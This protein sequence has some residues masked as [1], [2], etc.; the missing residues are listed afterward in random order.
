MIFTVK[1]RALVLII[2]L[3]A[4]PFILNLLGVDFASQPVTLDS[5]KLAS[6]IISTSNQSKPITNTLHHVFMEWIAICISMLI[7]LMSFLHFYKKRDIAVPIVGM[8]FLCTGLT[9]GFHI[10]AINSVVST[11]MLDDFIPFSWAFARFFSAT[12]I[13]SGIAINLWIFR[14]QQSVPTQNLQVTNQ[15]K[16]LAI[17]CLLLLTTTI[18]FIGFFSIGIEIPKT[19]FPNALLSRPYDILPLSMLVFCGALAW[20]WYRQFPTIIKYMLLLSLIPLGTAQLHMIF[21]STSLL[22]NDFNIAHMLKIIA[23]GCVFSGILID[24]LRQPSTSNPVTFNETND[25]LSRDIEGLVEVGKAA[26]PQAFTIPLASFVLAAI[27]SLL[28]GG[29]FYLNTEKLIRDQEVQE[30]KIESQLVE[31]LLSNFYKE[32][33]SDVLFLS[34]S[35]PVQELIKSIK[36]K[37]LNEQARWLNKLEQAFSLMLE[38]KQ[39][40][41]KIR[42]IGLENDGMELVNVFRDGYTIV[43]KKKDE[44]QTKIHR[45]YFKEMLSLSGGEIYFSQIELN[46]EH[47]EISVPYQPVIRVGTSIYDEESRKLF[48]FIVISA[49]FGFFVDNLLQTSLKDINFYLAN[50]K[51]DYLIHP[52]TSKTFGFDLGKRYLIQEEFPS[53]TNIIAEKKEQFIMLNDFWL[54]DESAIN[55]AN[56]VYRLIKPHYLNSQNNLHLLLTFDH[57]TIKKVLKN[58]R[59]HSLLIG[60]G[61]AVIALAI[62]VFGARRLTAPLLQTTSALKHF[63]HTGELLPLPTNSKDEIGVLARSFHNMLTLKRARDREL[64]EQKFALDQH[65]IVAVTDV[66]GTITFANEKFAEISGYTINELVGKNHNIVNSHYHDAEFWRK[67]YQTITRGKVWRGELRNITKQGK[68]Y[69]VDTTI[70]PFM[71]VNGKPESYIAIRTDITERKNMELALS[72]N[73]EHLELVID[74]TAVGI[75]DWKVQTD[76]VVFNERWAE[77]IG[78]QL[79][80]LEPTDINTWSGHCHPDDLVE[81]G[82]Q[83]ERHW[84]GETKYYSCEAR[85]MH[86][87]GSW[88]WVLDTGKVV[89]WCSDGKP[90]RMIGTHLDITE[91]K[92]AELA[93]TETMTLLESTIE[94]TDN[95]ILVTN[96]KGEVLRINT[97]FVQLWNL[98]KESAESSDESSL[99]QHI[100]AYLSDPEILTKSLSI[101]NEDPF[102]ELTEMLTLTDGK[103]IENISHPMLMNNT[104]VGRIWSFRDVTQRVVAEQQQK[105]L[106]ESTQTKLNVASVLNQKKPLAQRLDDVLN[107]ILTIDGIKQQGAIYLLD[108]KKQSIGITLLS[109]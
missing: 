106:L 47:R 24:L 52:D 59:N 16:I 20:N 23:Y 49:D 67:M 22:D 3:S 72:E 79:K 102:A 96:L 65:A 107:A 9:D 11:E 45:N 87:S 95:G 104:P 13:I 32:A 83:L 53:L 77:I 15:T 51:G 43:K 78:Y 21:G 100:K 108:E 17:V 30:L 82:K 39:N 91:R 60:L 12:L 42:Y 29:S 18:I 58:F 93:I 75:W 34:Q 61:L 28:V 92:N 56:G 71:G 101:F 88:V 90:K 64:A 10:L 74:S 68:I 46:K 55:N 89:E 97:R 85:M 105:Q 1:A 31:P 70:V 63:E 7:A 8:L 40:Y 94:S 84:N 27:V 14:N 37:Q 99:I 48:G 38:N 54:K 19:T 73:S 35:L 33:N 25:N 41:F 6:N 98:S 5:E 66:K 69:W 36:N 57:Q 26:R 109:R 76:E 103:I 86:K 80:E 81:S 4:L 62:A 2:T 50:E 44:M